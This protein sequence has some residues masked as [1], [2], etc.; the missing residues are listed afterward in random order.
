MI[1]H[2]RFSQSKNASIGR[3]IILLATT[4]R[5]ERRHCLFKHIAQRQLYDVRKVTA[6]TSSIGGLT[7]PFEK[8]LL[9]HKTRCGS[10][11]VV[12]CLSPST[13]LRANRRISP[14]I[15]RA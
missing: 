8:R 15:F 4:W 3:P 10:C 12:D 9:V 1:L 2:F 14:K 13:L 5:R 7:A 11:V 6:S